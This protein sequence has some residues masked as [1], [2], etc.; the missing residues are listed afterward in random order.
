MDGSVEIVAVFRILVPVTMH[1]GTVHHF[2][3]PGVHRIYVRGQ[4]GDEGIYPRGSTRW[5]E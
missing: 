4:G 1:D 3:L 2:T 5:E